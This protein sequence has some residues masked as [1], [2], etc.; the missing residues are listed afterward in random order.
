MYLHTLFCKLESQQV[1][2]VIWKL[3]AVPINNFFLTLF[4][5]T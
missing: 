5:G 3:T 2:S 4:P 1:T